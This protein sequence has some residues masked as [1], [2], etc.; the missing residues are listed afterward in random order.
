[1]DL[2]L[3][4]VAMPTIKPRFLGSLAHRKLL[5]RLSYP[6]PHSKADN[7]MRSDSFHFI[8]TGPLL[9]WGPTTLGN[10]LATT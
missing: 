3:G 5:Y 8:M 4:P 9:R 6:G 2:A 10:S 7:F 1:M